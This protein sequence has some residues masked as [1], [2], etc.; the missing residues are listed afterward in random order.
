MQPILVQILVQPTEIL[1]DVSNHAEETGLVGFDL[2]SI[3]IPVLIWHPQRTM[4][5]ISGDVS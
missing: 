4:G 2:I 3:G 1:V 5:G